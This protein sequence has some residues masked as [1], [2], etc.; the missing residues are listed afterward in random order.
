MTVIDSQKNK[1]SIHYF[2]SSLLFHT[3]KL[4][5]AHLYFDFFDNAFVFVLDFFFYY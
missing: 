5:L 4:K 2:E 1:G 3:C